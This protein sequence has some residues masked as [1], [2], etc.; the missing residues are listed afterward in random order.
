MEP[1]P[2]H[3]SHSLLAFP[4]SPLPSNAHP[5]NGFGDCPELIH[6]VRERIER[7][8]LTTVTHGRVGVW[9]YLY[10]QPVGANRDAGP[11][12]G[13]NELAPACSVTRVYDDRQVCSLLEDRDG[14]D[15]ESVACGA[16]KRA[17]ASLA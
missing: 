11:R 4:V 14:A 6:H 1:L 13:R 16:L 17:D 5:P 2:F 10:D 9:V 12:E 7:H 15:V 3:M 8:A